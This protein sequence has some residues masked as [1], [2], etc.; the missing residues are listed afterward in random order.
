MKTNDIHN[1][2]YPLF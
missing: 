1:M 2:N